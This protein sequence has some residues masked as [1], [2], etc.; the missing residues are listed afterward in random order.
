MPSQKAIQKWDMFVHILD[1]GCREGG[2]AGHLG[3]VWGYG[4]CGNYGRN[5]IYGGHTADW[6][7][8][9]GGGNEGGGLFG[10]VW[11]AL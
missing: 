9:L 11:A 3:G 4:I 1:M 2:C 8:L 5:G 6:A 7:G 10:G